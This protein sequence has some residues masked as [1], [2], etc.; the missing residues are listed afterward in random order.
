MSN[1][2]KL[3][4]EAMKTASY[5]LNAGIDKT[6]SAS[7][8]SSLVKEASE[9]A[10]ALE[11]MSMASAS[12]GSLAG[13]ARA[14]MIRDFH[15]AATA[16]RLG[17]KLA[18]DVGE[19][20]TMA[21]GVQAHAPEH[22]KTRLMPKK[23]VAGNP[24][25]SSSP[26]S[27]GKTMLESYKQADSGNTLYDILM[28]QKEA[29]DVGEMDASMAAPNIPSSNENSNRAILNDSYVLQGVSKQEAK[30][31]TRARLA[32]A[33]ASTSD[34]LGDQTVRALFP[35][36]YQAGGLKKTAEA[37][38]DNKKMSKKK[39][40]ALA[41]AAALGTVGLGTAGY[42]GHKKLKELTSK[43]DDLK[44]DASMFPSEMKVAGYSVADRLK[45]MME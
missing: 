40:A 43:L 3:I 2:K 25:V 42:K 36:A 35:Q 14:E 27:K 8:Q 34:T 37:E 23:E 16:Q 26:D 31:P 30:A 19:G 18:G 24:M 9:L 22:G 4:D 7:T 28:H 17:V 11:Y 10:N 33:F 20:P 32:E 45:R 13:N 15:K 5:R 6:A 39:K 12:D 44:M 41:A 21:S 1:Y 29:G 38:D